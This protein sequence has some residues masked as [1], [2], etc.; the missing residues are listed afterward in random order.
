MEDGK[1]IDPGRRMFMKLAAAG[2]AAISTQA[3]TAVA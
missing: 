1:T 3:G 2:A